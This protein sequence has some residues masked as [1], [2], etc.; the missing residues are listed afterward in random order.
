M[1]QKYSY[2]IALWLAA[3]FT[4]CNEEEVQTFSDKPGINFLE[5][6][7]S[8]NNVSWGNGYTHLYSTVNYYDIYASGKYEMTEGE[9]PIR[10]QLE[11]RLSEIPLKVKFKAQ[12]V[13]GF[14]ELEVTVPEEA[15]EIKAGEYTANT[16]IK[17]KK[18]SSY[19]KEFRAQIVIDYANSDVIAGT[20]ERQSYLIR[21]IDEFKPEKMH[22][23]SFD[24]WNDYYQSC[25]GD[26]GPEKIRFVL[27]VIKDW[28][29]S[30]C[31]YS[32]YYR[33]YPNYVS[34]YGIP[35]YMPEVIAALETYNNEHPGAE[36][37]EHDGTPVTFPQP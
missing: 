30:A 37:K 23:N 9:V 24:D 1:K 8:S 36:L 32:V 33:D 29:D 11:G 7:E 19:D 35:K 5:R 10:V 12:P 21:V 26:Y 13:D 16:V 31:Y 18:P 28:F 17:Y 25:L 22:L 27:S 6:Y 3:S 14:G 15:V 34:Y 20:K 2:A 4:A